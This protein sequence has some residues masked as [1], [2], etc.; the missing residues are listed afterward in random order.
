[1]FDG[2]GQRI[3]L[4]KTSA[5][6]GLGLT[7]DGAKHRWSQIVQVDLRSVKTEIFKKSAQI[8]PFSRVN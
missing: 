2:T 7:A 5:G 3:L 8:A 6:L 1:M 4:K